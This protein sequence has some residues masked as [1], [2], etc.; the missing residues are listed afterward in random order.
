MAAMTRIGPPQR[1]HPSEQAPGT[2][3]VAPRAFVL[4]RPRS[5]GIHLWHEARTFLGEGVPQLGGRGPAG[6]R[7]GKRLLR[8]QREREVEPPRGCRRLPGPLAAGD[9]HLGRGE[10]LCEPTLAPRIAR[11]ARLQP[12]RSIRD[13]PRGRAAQRQAGSPWPASSPSRAWARSV[14][15]FSATSRCNTVSWGRRGSYAGAASWSS[16]DDMPS[17]HRRAPCQ[18]KCQ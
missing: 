15:R 2:H 8:P 3:S 12:P 18:H 7:Q 13:D 11:A 10:A 4:P 9:P 1:H 14:S 5:C 6:S 16:H 17:A